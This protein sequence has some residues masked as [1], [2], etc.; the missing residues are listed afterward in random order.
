M[1]LK[2]SHS[3]SFRRDRRSVR[4]RNNRFDYIPNLVIR[5]Q[6]GENPHP[7][8]RWCGCA[9][10]LGVYTLVGIRGGGHGQHM[11]ELDWE[12]VVRPLKRS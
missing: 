8:R 1:S 12:L 4:F 5:V 6:L 11:E 2:T 3:K 7:G 9:S 10:S